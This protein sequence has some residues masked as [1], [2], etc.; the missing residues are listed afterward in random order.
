M[1]RKLIMITWLPE[2]TPIRLKLL[3][4]AVKTKIKLEFRVIN[5]EFAEKYSDF[6]DES[7][8]NWNG[9][10]ISKNTLLILV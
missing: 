10:F 4:G 2:D 3:I 6:Y 5:E 1:R 9:P 7:I 8:K